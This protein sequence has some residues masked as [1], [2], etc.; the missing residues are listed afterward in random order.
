[1]LTDAM[2]KLIPHQP[3]HGVR[4]E[5]RRFDCGDKAG[6]IEANIAFALKHP[7]IG[8]AVRRTVLEYAELVKD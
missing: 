3:F 2:A 8:P 4:Y 5:G 6:F 1:Q 7:K